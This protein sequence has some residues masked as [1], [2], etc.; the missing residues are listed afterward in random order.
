MFNFINLSL[1]K[2][3]LLERKKRIKKELEQVAKKSSR[4]GSGYDTKF[5]QYGR[6]EDENAEEVATFIDSL[7]VGE[8]LKKSLEEIEIA[9]KKISQGKYGI[10]EICGGKISRER[11]KILPTA[12]FCL[13]CKKK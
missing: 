3:D 5:P 6:S 8:N 9:L 1:V 11:L 12:R 7:S 2:K 4:S 10:C 13:N